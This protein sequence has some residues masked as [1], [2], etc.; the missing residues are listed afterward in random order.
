MV[1]LVVFSLTALSCNLFL[2]IICVYS[3]LRLCRLAV[4][5]KKALGSSNCQTGHSTRKWTGLFF[6][7]FSTGRCRPEFMKIMRNWH[8]WTNNKPNVFNTVD[9]TYQICKI[10]GSTFHP[11]FLIVWLPISTVNCHIVSYYAG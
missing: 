2:C 7:F 8:I 10:P 6:F 3:S 9:N 5:F 4:A 1:S 11:S